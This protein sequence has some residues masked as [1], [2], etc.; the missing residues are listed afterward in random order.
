MSVC[1]HPMEMPWGLTF[2]CDTWSTG[3]SHWSPIKAWKSTPL[4]KHCLAEEAPFR[5]I[6]DVVTTRDASLWG[7]TTNLD[8]ISSLSFRQFHLPTPTS[9]FPTNLS[10]LH[11]RP[12]SATSTEIDRSRRGTIGLVGASNAATGYVGEGKDVP[13]LSRNW[14]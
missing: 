5:V 4:K 11:L 7:P 12:N 6:V 1:G 3:D 9:F 13:W 2:T 8:L 10:P 14:G